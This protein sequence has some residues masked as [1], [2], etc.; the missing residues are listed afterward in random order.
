MHT[1]ELYQNVG[2]ELGE[3]KVVVF[4]FLSWFLPQ[5]II[6]QMESNSVTKNHSCPVAEKTLWA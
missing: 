2:V 4:E 1:Y 5:S 6:G 3:Q